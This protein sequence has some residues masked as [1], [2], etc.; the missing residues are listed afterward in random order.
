MATL[1]TGTE[2]HSILNLLNEKLKLKEAVEGNGITQ[3]PLD[4]STNFDLYKITEREAFNSFELPEDVKINGGVAIKFGFTEGNWNNQIQ[5]GNYIPYLITDK[6]S[7]VAIASFLIATQSNYN[8]KLDDVAHFVFPMIFETSN[9]GEADNAYPSFRKKYGFLP[10]YKLKNDVP[11]YVERFL[12]NGC[13]RSAE[14]SD[15]LEI[16]ASEFK[17]TNNSVIEIPNDIKQINNYAITSN[18]F[19][20]PDN[21]YTVVIP[22]TVEYL[23][24]SALDFVA[25]NIIYACR[26]EE[27]PTS[28]GLNDGAKE[29]IVLHYGETEEQRNARMET[30]Y[31]AKAKEFDDKV[32]EL[33]N[34]IT[35]EKYTYNYKLDSNVEQLNKE[36]EELEI[37]V[38]KYLTTSDKVKDLI[39]KQKD[40]KQA[41]EQNRIKELNQD[42]LVIVDN[43]FV[44]KLYGNYASIINSN[45]KG[46]ADEIHVPAEIN[47]IKVTRIEKNAFMYN[48]S[49]SKIFLPETIVYIGNSAFY[50]C[51]GAK[52]GFP[53]AVLDDRNKA[54]KV[55]LAANAF[56]CNMFTD[57]SASNPGDLYQFKMK[58]GVNRYN[59]P[60]FTY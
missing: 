53:K 49:F 37:E 15:T 2:K 50:G 18:N 47:G 12:A 19:I 7:N 56:N 48:Q 10:F 11:N 17:E 14:S 6:N 54:Q 52:I 34:T 1:W 46:P 43:T 60:I 23:A 39:K 55:K 35:D 45:A 26:G 38:K 32:M 27:V 30:K 41:F 31:K 9:L 58:N 5:N 29:K 57:S 40:A 20:N 44:V 51:K 4:D 22:E 28:W 24:P 16:I 42:N 36:Y 13:V 21:P 33:Y 59:S 25:H 3:I 8:I